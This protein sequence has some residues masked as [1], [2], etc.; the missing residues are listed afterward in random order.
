MLTLLLATGDSTSVHAGITAD[1]V[2][3]V[4]LL[5]E[6]AV[7]RLGDATSQRKPQAQVDFFLD[8]V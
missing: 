8:I 7:G 2:A 1:D 4:V 3:A 5:G 6:L